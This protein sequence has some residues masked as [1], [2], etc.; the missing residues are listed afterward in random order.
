MM[1]MMIKMK[2]ARIVTV[3][4]LTDKVHANGHARGEEQTQ[5]LQNQNLLK[6][7]TFG[8]KDEKHFP[9]WSVLTESPRRRLLLMKL[10]PGKRTPISVCPSCSN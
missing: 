8:S 4:N 6:E 5:L 3:Y 10:L 7:L 9:T 1:K 2:M